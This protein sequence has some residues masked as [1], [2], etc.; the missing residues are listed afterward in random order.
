MCF[1]GGS[2]LIRKLNE[3]QMEVGLMIIE[4]LEVYCADIDCSLCVCYR[5]NSIDTLILA[6]QIYGLPSPDTC[7]EALHD[8][9]WSEV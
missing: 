7:S 2:G 3:I 9:I 5:C 8:K 6:Y 1:G 4:L